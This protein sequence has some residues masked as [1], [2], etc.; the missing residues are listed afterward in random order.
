MNAPFI[1]FSKPIIKLNVRGT[2]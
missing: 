2:A 1:I